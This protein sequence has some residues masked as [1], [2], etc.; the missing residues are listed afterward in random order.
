M[1]ELSIG[2][3]EATAS[4]IS[5]ARASESAFCARA[6][7][8]WVFRSVS[9]WFDSVTV[10]LPKIQ[11]GAGAERLDLALGLRH[12]V[13]QLLELAGQP[14][15]GGARLILLRHLLEGQVFFR[16]QVGDLRRK[17]GI[18]GLEFDRDD[19]RLVEREGLQPVEI[20]RQHPLLERHRHRVLEDADGA[21][22]R[23]RRELL[24]GRV[25]LRQLGKV[26][27]LDDLARE[28][29]RQHELHLAGHRFRI[30]R[31]AV[32]GQL[33]GFRPQEDV[34]PALDQHARFGFEPRRHEIDGDEGCG[35]DQYRRPDDRTLVAPY[36]PRHRAETDLVAGIGLP[37]ALNATTHADS[38]PVNSGETSLV[39]DKPLWLLA[40]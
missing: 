6:P 25:E 38:V 29:A 35:C 39:H 20:G 36:R 22:E 1:S 2:C 11:V 13:A 28:I 32:H 33:F 37:S 19:A 8:T 16:D 30:D 21:Q 34:F 7:D 27:L 9:C 18:G 23:Q 40:R 17:L 10:P 5:R 15:A 14:F 24:E 31:A 12:L 4:R 3:P 26:Q